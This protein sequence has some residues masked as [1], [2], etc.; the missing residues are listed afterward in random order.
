MTTIF[1]HKFDRITLPEH[2]VLESSHTLLPDPTKASNFAWNHVEYVGIP[3]DIKVFDVLFKQD[4]ESIPQFQ[5][6]KLLQDFVSLLSTKGLHVHARRMSSKVI[7]IRVF[8]NSDFSCTEHPEML[9][10]EPLGQYH[11]PACGEMVVAG[12]TH[13]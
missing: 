2:V 1:E 12:F 11:C 3:S 10:F 4:D 9:I 8:K 5:Y 13:I 6:D 7:L